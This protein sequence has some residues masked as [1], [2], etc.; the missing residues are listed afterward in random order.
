ML[1]CYYDNG[2]I[3]PTNQVVE[4]L[5]IPHKAYHISLLERL[6]SVGRPV[7]AVRGQIRVYTMNGMSECDSCF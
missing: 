3:L 2:N 4:S 7:D 1:V 6:T 5:I